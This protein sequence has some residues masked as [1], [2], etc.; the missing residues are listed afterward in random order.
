MS[1]NLMESSYFENIRATNIN[2]GQRWR[3]V[4]FWVKVTKMSLNHEPLL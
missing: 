3:C 2:M 4:L 1:E